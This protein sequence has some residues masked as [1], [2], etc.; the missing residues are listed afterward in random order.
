MNRFKYW[1]LCVHRISYY[2]HCN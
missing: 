2:F 1:H